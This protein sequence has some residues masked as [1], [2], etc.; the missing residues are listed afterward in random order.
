M[1]EAKKAQV[2]SFD[3][4]IAIIVFMVIATLFFVFFSSRMKESPEVMLDYE[5]KSLRNVVAVSSEDTMTPSSF[6]LRNRVDYE[7]LVEL[8]KKTDQASALRDMKNDF[9]IRNDFCIY[10]VDE[11]GEIL[12]IVYLDN[13]DTPRYVFGIGKKL[14]IGEFNNR[15]VECGVKYTSTEL[16][17]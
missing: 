2:I 12:P 15:N 5:S 6:V 7:K 1:R 8:A 3:L 10:F 11:N 17:I 13:D 4:M 16:G 14:K 9:G